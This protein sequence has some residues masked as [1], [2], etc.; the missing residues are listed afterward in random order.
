MSERTLEDCKSYFGNLGPFRGFMADPEP[1]TFDEL[2]R[3]MDEQVISVFG[4][5]HQLMGRSYVYDRYMGEHEP[6]RF[7]AALYDNPFLKL[8]HWCVPQLETLFA[9]HPRK[10]WAYKGYVWDDVQ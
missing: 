9:E 5:P 10:K 3:R 7:H 8:P 4:V 1:P 2:V 6:P